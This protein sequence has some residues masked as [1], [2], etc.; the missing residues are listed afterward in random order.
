ML[1][2]HLQKAKKEDKNLNKQENQNV[3]ELYKACSQRYMAY[4]N[5]KDLTRRTVSDKFLRDKIFSVAKIQNIMD[6]K[7]V[8]S[9]WFLN[10]L[11]KNLLCLFDERP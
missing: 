2:D 9:Q 4:G 3:N 10:F 1:A 5:L 8:L 11:V 6:I 7:G